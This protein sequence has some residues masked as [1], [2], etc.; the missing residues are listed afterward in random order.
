[1][2][3]MCDSSFLLRAVT[4]RRLMRHMRADTC[5]CGA[6]GGWGAGTEEMEKLSRKMIAFQSRKQKAARQVSHIKS[7]LRLA[8]SF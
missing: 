5:A 8:A 2:E 6:K 3:A 7:E 1:M 4:D